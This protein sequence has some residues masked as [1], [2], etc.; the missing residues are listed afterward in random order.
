MLANGINVLAND[1]YSIK[2]VHENKDFRTRY[3]LVT[4]MYQAK[5]EHHQNGNCC[6]IHGNT[7]REVAPEEVEDR[8]LETTARTVEAKQRLV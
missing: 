7:R 4:D 8:A 3:K 1:Q 5:Y 2:P 6:P